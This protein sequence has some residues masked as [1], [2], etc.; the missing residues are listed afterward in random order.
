MAPVT[1]ETVEVNSTQSAPQE[2]SSQS[3]GTTGGSA[4]HSRSDV[5]SLEVPVKVHG[6]R[7]VAGDGAAS[8]TE[9][10][11][12]Q[13]ATMIVF[14][15]G[16]VLRMTTSVSQGQMLVLTNLKSRQDAIC[17]VVKVRNLPKAHHYV[18]VEF[19][20]P[21][22]GYW[23]VY[24]PSQG[25]SGA[26]NPPKASSTVR[27]A[28]QATSKVSL[29]APP[30]T[31]NPPP[32]QAVPAAKPAET[33][34]P[35]KDVKPVSP[36]APATRAPAAKPASTFVSLGTKEEVQPAASATGEP[37]LGKT[38]REVASR[39]L[40]VEETTKGAEA[41]LHS[42]TAFATPADIDLPSEDLNQTAGSLKQAAEG[43]GE[44]GEFF[45]EGGSFGSISEGVASLGR[46][47]NWMLVSAGIAALFVA[48]AAGAWFFHARTPSHN[49]AGNPAPTAAVPPVGQPNASAGQPSAT[50]TTPGSAPGAT[51]AAHANEPRGGTQRAPQLSPSSLAT[52]PAG[53]PASAV[54]GPATETANRAPATETRPPAIQTSAT[55]AEHPDRVLSAAGLKAHPLSSQRSTD[56]VNQAPVIDATAVAGQPGNV[57][58]PGSSSLAL[59]PPTPERPVRVGGTVKAPRLISTVLP[60]YPMAAK[61]AHIQG[62][63]VVD[64][65]VTKSGTIGRMSV[66]SGPMVLR[67]AAL[68]A[69][70]QWKYRP[71]ELDGEPV[72][73]KMLIKIQFRL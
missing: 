48:V 64:T 35:P 17:R 56:P 20:R 53:R 21:Q 50:T 60:I 42:R 49:A 61:M 41:T 15:E 72:E 71:S 26:P 1:K 66:V 25:Q 28:P 57:P 12:E 67:Q 59:P 68:E 23:G 32:P 22:P 70:R 34:L 39:A 44:F 54:S 36:P 3:K 55:P 7:Y 52:V 29:G 51:S 13:T 46:H 62:D 24:F 5:V 63:V 40:P 31:A 6:S 73:V 4:G 16:G 11:E 58:I 10:F 37:H 14:P 33:R 69:L 45:G 38:V 47:Q 30:K 19:T 65:Q 8:Q 9:R 18:E 27:I 2:S 43:A